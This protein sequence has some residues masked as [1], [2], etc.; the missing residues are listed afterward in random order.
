MDTVGRL[1]SA[2]EYDPASGP[3]GKF[4]SRV[5]VG[6]VA[7]ILVRAVEANPADREPTGRVGIYNVCDDC[8][9]P[10]EEVLAF[11]R[12]VF[13]CVRDGLCLL[14]RNLREC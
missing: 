6:D 9:A 4:V 13:L 12:K 2:A 10:R 1:G 7:R 5:H 8:P 3:G 11:A 14:S